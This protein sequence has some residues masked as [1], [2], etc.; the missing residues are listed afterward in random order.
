MRKTLITY[1]NPTYLRCF[2][3]APINKIK[4]LWLG[5]TFKKNHAL[6]LKLVLTSLVISGPGQK[7]SFV[8]DSGYSTDATVFTAADSTV[9]SNAPASA[10]VYA[11][12][13]VATRPFIPCFKAAATARPVTGL[14]TAGG[15]FPTAQPMKPTFTY[16]AVKT[17]LMLPRTTATTTASYPSSSSTASRVPSFGPS[18][19]KSVP[20]QQ[21]QQV[22]S[23]K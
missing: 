15:F 11:T 18:F 5:P 12:P 4:E 23:L 8:S 2:S 21:D 10:R 19:S 13:A 9:N 3:P 1:L 16:Q 17:N 6:S 20:F 14:T 22:S 7:P